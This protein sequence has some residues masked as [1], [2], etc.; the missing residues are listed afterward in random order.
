M[1]G[2]LADDR[3]RRH[4][5]QEKQWDK[6]FSYAAIMAD[7]VYAPARA[8]YEEMKSNGWAMGYLTARLERNRQATV[9]WLMANSFDNPHTAIL[10]PEESADLRPA[11]FKTAVLA[12]L[13][14]SERYDSVILVDNDPLVVARVTE[15]L[16]SHHVFFA[17]W[18]ENP[19]MSS[20]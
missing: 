16:G 2:T 19:A 17:S 11:E 15:E 6:Y 5:Y 9:D 1:D 3:Q 4:F 20:I 10:R 13:L 8:L 14:A 12:D 7:S 18:D